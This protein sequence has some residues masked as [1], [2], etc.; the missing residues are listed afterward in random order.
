MSFLFK[1]MKVIQNTL[2]SNKIDEN[3]LR[4]GGIGVLANL[5]MIMWNLKLFMQTKTIKLT[6]K[7]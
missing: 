6:H 4:G 2:F 3:T 5:M 7:V 1:N